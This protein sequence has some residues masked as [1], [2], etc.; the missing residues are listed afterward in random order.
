MPVN[1]LKGSDKSDTCLTW[2]T[3]HDDPQSFR[4][5]RR[6]DVW[7]QLTDETFKAPSKRIYLKWSF[8]RGR[9]N[10][11]S[12][13]LTLALT[14]MVLQLTRVKYNV[15]RNYRYGFSII[16]QQKSMTQDF[17]FTQ[18]QPESKCSRA[19]SPDSNVFLVVN[20]WINT[21]SSP[22][23]TFCCWLFWGIKSSLCT[24]QRQGMGETVT[25]KEGRCGGN[26]Y[27]KKKHCW[28]SVNCTL[29]LTLLHA[30]WALWCISLKAL[31]CV[32]CPK[33]V[34]QNC[35]K[36]SLVLF[37]SEWWMCMYSRR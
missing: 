31:N 7:L 22:E 20:H 10:D 30:L 13:N 4:K 15:L 28:S 9:H 37:Y 8:V 19:S 1:T 27:I 36:K 11:S 26:R 21:I 23:S 2:S 35:Q 17:L 34:E 14:I 3:F 6:R 25:V 16:V 33:S 32:R 24:E 18:A 29:N 5:F 12:I